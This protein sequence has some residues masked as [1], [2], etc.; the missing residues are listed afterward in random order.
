MREK[1]FTLIEL[2]IVVAIIVIIAA[3][4]IPNLLGARLVSNETAALATLRTL[5]ASQA[6]FQTRASV[7]TDNNGIGEYGTFYEMASGQPPTLS[8]AFRSVNGDGE[9]SKSGYHF[10][11]YLPNATAVGQK[12]QAGGGRSGAVDPELAETTWCAYAWPTSRGKSGNRTFFVNQSG[13]IT[14]TDA[15]EYSGPD[16]GP[17]A[18]SA[19]DGSGNTITG[20]VAIAA[21]GRDTNFWKVSG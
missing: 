19:F 3:I 15:S 7:D 8:S 16:S 1:G 17:M 4:A 13:D 5:T 11:V 12:E 21:T 20:S 2:M 14:Y 9:V 10:A 6:Q 18:N